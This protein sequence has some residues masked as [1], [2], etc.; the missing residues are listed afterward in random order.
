MGLTKTQETIMSFLRKMNH[1][2]NNTYIQVLSKEEQ[3][4]V[5]LSRINLCLQL[6][7]HLN[8]GWEHPY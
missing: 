8:Q 7:M 2:G 1:L 6:Q 4:Q 5:A 3:I